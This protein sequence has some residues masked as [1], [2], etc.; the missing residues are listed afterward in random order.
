MGMID[1]SKKEIWEEIL[2]LRVNFAFL[3]RCLLLS[4]EEQL[5]G[6]KVIQC[7]DL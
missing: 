2:L 5:L 6:I 1:K 3:E 7:I 4:S